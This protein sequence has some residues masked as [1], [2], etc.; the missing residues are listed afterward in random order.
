MYVA[1]LH[2][3]KFYHNVKEKMS[4]LNQW[5]AHLASCFYFGQNQSQRFWHFHHKD[6]AS[7]H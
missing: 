5:Y 6:T 4:V 2:L 1:S 3:G 7:R